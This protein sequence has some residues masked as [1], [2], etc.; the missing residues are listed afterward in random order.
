[1]LAHESKNARLTQ[2]AYQ[3]EPGGPLDVNRH[4]Y[5]SI[6]K[7]PRTLVDKWVLPIRSGKAWVVKKGQICRI[8]TVEGAQV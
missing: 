4:L 1:M 7:S 8:T 5:D 2:A 3:A 6:A